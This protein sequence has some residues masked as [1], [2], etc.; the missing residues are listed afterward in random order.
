MRASKRRARMTKKNHADPLRV[1]QFVETLVGEDMH[2]KRVLS[3]S[4]G[5]L[6][7]MH[8]ASLSVHAIGQGLA[9]SK[10]LVRKHSV[11]QVDRL[12]S[13]SKLDIWELFGLWV[14][15][16]VGERREL[17]VALDWTEF[18]GDGQGVIAAYLITSHGR[19]TPLVWKTVEKRTLKQNRNRY[20]DEV[21]ERLRE[22]VPDGAK[23]TILAED[24]KS[25]V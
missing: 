23:V 5:V 13:N 19:A 10:E 16:V 21:L 9:A 18:D 11:K 15:Y 3:L 20:E 24:R 4:N 12:L 25:V 14:P 8:A 7:V 6:G 17:V 22:V 2:A 1:Q